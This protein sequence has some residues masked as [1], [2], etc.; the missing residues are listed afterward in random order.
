MTGRDVDADP[1][2]LQA[3]AARYSRP[4]WLVVDFALDFVDPRLRRFY[5]IWQGKRDGTRLPKRADFDPLD[6]KE[7]LGRLFISERAPDGEDFIYRL[8]GTEIVEAVGTDATGQR[9][10]DVVGKPTD[11]LVMFCAAERQPLR[12]HGYLVWRKKSYMRFEAVM[13]PL[14][15]DGVTVDRLIGEMAFGR[16]GPRPDAAAFPAP[17]DPRVAD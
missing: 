1:G 8:I 6:L 11:D 4:P 7:H 9:M 3:V 17:D 10:G 2:D 5:E 13:L 15:D 16:P 14:A 12:H